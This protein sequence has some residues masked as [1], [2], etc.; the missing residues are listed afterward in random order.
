MLI[1]CGHE[2]SIIT[3]FNFVFFTEKKNEPEELEIIDGRA[4]WVAEEGRTQQFPA[5]PAE[6]QFISRNEGRVKFEVPKI[7]V[8]FVL[9]KVF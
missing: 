1:F 7:P 4:L 6:G 8:V 2:C 9:G 3:Y 5:T